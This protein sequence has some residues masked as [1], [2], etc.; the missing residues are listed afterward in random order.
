MSISYY[1]IPTKNKAEIGPI[2]E[3]TATNPKK[4]NEAA[5]RARFK[6]DSRLQ[7]PDNGTI[8]WEWDNEYIFIDVLSTHVLVTHNTGDSETQIFII[9]D[10]LQDLKSFGLHI[11]DPQ[12]GDWYP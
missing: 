1:A 9:M 8:R 6:K 10:V 12:F 7:V 5:I 2:V 4:I 11:W 3:R